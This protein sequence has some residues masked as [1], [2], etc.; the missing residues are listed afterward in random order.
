MNSEPHM[1]ERY[2][3]AAVYPYHYRDNA[4][5]ADIVLQISANKMTLVFHCHEREKITSD[6]TVTA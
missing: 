3:H 6:D 1:L 5:Q 4:W 2:M